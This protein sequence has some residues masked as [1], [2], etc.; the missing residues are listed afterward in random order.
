MELADFAEI[1]DKG[2]VTAIA[3]LLVWRLD[4]RLEKVGAK[5]GELVAEIRAQRSAR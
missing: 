5:L 4:R 3:L 2:G 1:I